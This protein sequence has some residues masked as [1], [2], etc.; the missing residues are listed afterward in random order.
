MVDIILRRIEMIAPPLEENF[1][2][3]HAD[4]EHTQWINQILATFW[5]KI[6]IWMNVKMRP[7]LN[8]HLPIRY[9]V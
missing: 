4:A 3:H 2:N 1:E 9:V 5:K 7:I 6:V 8:K